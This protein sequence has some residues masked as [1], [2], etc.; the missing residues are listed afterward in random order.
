MIEA[1]ASYSFET[2]RTN[3]NL[4]VL[5]V[6]SK[7]RGHQVTIRQVDS[8][9]VEHLASF[10]ELLITCADSSPSPPVKNDFLE[11]G[12]GCMRFDMFLIE[13]GYVSSDISLQPRHTYLHR[14][15]VMM[16]EFGDVAN[17]LR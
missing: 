5:D 16:V 2:Q 7:T 3:S 14:L 1:E 10:S 13:S 4:L 17:F 8:K 9:G 6:V 11:L 15:E 12:E